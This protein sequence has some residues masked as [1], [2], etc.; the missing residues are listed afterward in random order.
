MYF[1]NQIPIGVRSSK[2]TVVKRGK[3]MHGRIFLSKVKRLSGLNKQQQYT[4]VPP[5]SRL[6]GPRKK[7]RNRLYQ[8]KSFTFVLESLESVSYDNLPSSKNFLPPSLIVM[9]IVYWQKGYYRNARQ[10]DKAE[11]QCTK[12]R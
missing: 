7:S 10:Q 11:R 4:V 5:N 6:I 1:M 2:C 3:R 8:L 12:A 9:T